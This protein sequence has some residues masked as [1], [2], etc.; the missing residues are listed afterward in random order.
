MKC[1]KCNTI[2]HEPDA[3]YCHKCGT[4]LENV[5]TFSRHGV[6]ETSLKFNGRK[7]EILK[8]KGF[9]IIERES[10]VQ[11]NTDWP[12]VGSGVCS[13]QKIRWGN[14]VRYVLLLAVLVEHIIISIKE[15]NIT[16]ADGVQGYALTTIGANISIF[17]ITLALCA[18]IGYFED[19]KRGL[20]LYYEWL[21]FITAAIMPILGFWIVSNIQNGWTL[22]LDGI[23]VGIVF[24]VDF[25]LPDFID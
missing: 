23:F 9:P 13:L 5:S 22:L 25:V 18:N 20:R 11:D 1:P 21:H 19:K 10:P 24:F 8:V 15:S 6:R 14:L 12:E 7:T 4:E 16:D 3:K 17:I 2:D